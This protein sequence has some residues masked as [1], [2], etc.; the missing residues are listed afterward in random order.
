VQE[1]RGWSEERGVTLSQRS[2]EFAH[3]YRYFPEPDL[4]PVFVSREWVEALRARLPELPDA[5]RERYEREFGLSRYDAGQLAA[6]AAVSAFFE[7]AMA[8]YP[9]PKVVANWVQGELFRLLKEADVEIDET[10]VTP[11]HLV[12]VL[13]L[14]DAGKLNGALAKQ[15]FDEVFATGERPAAI[16]ATRGLEQVSDSGELERIIGEV[17]AA[18]PQPVADYRA[19]KETA[20]NFLKGQVMK[21][22]K[23]KANPAVA[24][25][26]LVAQL[27]A[28]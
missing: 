17:L 1:T 14:L 5:K 18:N 4:P 24:T 26:L 22:T 21:A 28:E 16:M 12:E 9:Q 7:R 6:T 27:K 23:G 15:V 3:D 19:G 8:L 25:D 13:Q 20:I 2:K 11:E 10:R